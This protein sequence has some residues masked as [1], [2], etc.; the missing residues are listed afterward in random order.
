M[1]EGTTEKVDVVVEEEVVDIIGEK[2]INET[3]M[4]EVD[5]AQQETTTPFSD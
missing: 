1:A 2:E 5:L 4:G 3:E